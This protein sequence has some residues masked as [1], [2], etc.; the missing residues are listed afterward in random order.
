MMVFMLLLWLLQSAIAPGMPAEVTLS[1]GAGP[2]EIPYAGTA[3]EVLTLT[4]RSLAD[5]PVDPTL[6]VLYE[7]RRIAFNDDHQTQIAGL[8]PQD[9]ALTGLVL[10]ES[11][12]YLFR[13]H[14]FNGAQAGRLEVA[15]LSDALV[16]PCPPSPEVVTLPP[17]HPFEC[18]LD[19]KAGQSV[20]LSAADVDGQLDPVLRLYSP[21]QSLLAYNDDHE[22]ANLTLNVLDAHISAYAVAEAGLYRV[23]IS[24]FAGA[25]GN[26]TLVIQIES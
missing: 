6:E 14:S 1:A 11:G 17:H 16:A 5:E 22:T 24:D 7:G 19:L 12:D 23:Q 9:A 21:E 8:G 13:I 25:A 3:N 18:L 20:T 4:V 2:L 15:L 10:P 26:L